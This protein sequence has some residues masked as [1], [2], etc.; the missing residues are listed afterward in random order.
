MVTGYLSRHPWNNLGGQENFW[1]LPD[2]FAME[3]THLIPLARWMAQNFSPG[4]RQWYERLLS[5][6]FL[7]LIKAGKDFKP[8]KGANFKTYATIRMR[9]AIL[10]CCRYEIDH[11]SRHYRRLVKNGLMPNVKLLGN[12]FLQPLADAGKS[13]AMVDVK[14]EVDVILSRCPEEL[15]RI[16]IAVYLEQGNQTEV[17]ASMGISKRVLARTII[18]GI[19]RVREI[20][21]I[22]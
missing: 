5:A 16:L 10:D 20:Q 8:T 21:N 22:Q 11:M 13:L 7:G 9:G 4:N 2:Q 18:R 6:A 19:S 17:A 1:A 12:E 14:D 3:I 15:R